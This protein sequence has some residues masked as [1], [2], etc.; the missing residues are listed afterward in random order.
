MIFDNI[1]L[2]CITFDAIFFLYKFDS[3]ESLIRAAQNQK[4]TNT[5]VLAK[6]LELK[7]GSKVMLTVTID[8][9]DHLIN[10]QIGQI[11]FF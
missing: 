6:T 5:G 10:G 11:T 4:L 2:F 1:Y 9:V 7:I 3:I 8:I